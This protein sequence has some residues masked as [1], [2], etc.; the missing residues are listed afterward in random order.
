MRIL[1]ISSAR[2]LGGGE[3]HLIDLVKG[4]S[5]RSHQVDLLLRPHSPLK[6]HL[7]DFKTF[8]LPLGGLLDLKSIYRMA[9]LLQNY[10]LAHAHYARDYPGVAISVKLARRYNPRLCY[11]FTRHHYLPVKRNI[12]YRS[13]L[14]NADAAIAVSNHVANTLCERL[15]WSVSSIS[16]LKPVPTIVRIPNWVDHRRYLSHLPKEEAKASLGVPIDK[17]LLTCINQLHENKGQHLLLEACAK[18]D[19]IHII[20]AGKEHNSKHYTLRLQKDAERLGLAK[21]V[22]FAGYVTNIPS[23]LA[24]TDICVIPSLHEA[25]SIVCLEAMSA[26]RPVVASRVGGLMELIEDDV[27]GLHF[28]PGSSKE[29]ACSLRKLID[30]PNLRDTIAE[31]AY[32]QVLAYYSYDHVLDQIDR[33]F[34]EL[35]RNRSG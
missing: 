34:Q 26:R 21:Q 9:Q 5:A 33:L 35:L 4:L 6:D 18:M 12:F 14:G 15:K 23:L 25:F 32:K 20:F 22:T 19:N 29:L 8:E 2:E 7:V 16:A 3:R 30:N 17:L 28:T 13:I 1:Q 27:T 24:A 11:V 10:D 31:H